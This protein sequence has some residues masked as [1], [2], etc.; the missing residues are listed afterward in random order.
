[1]IDSSQV[2]E[3]MTVRC[4]DGRKLGRVLSCEE[5]AFIVEEELFGVEYVV[6]YDYVMAVSGDETQLTLPR[7]NFMSE[8]EAPSG[9]EEEEEG[10]RFPVRRHEYLGALPLSYGDEGGGGF[11]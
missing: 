3:G 8:P 1:V 4:S 5:A 2:H 6:H 11:L 9:E 7:D 10:F